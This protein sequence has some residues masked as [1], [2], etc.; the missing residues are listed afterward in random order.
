M[1]KETYTPEEP[2]AAIATAL[3]PAAL[4]IV[5]TSGKNCIDLVSKAFSRPKALKSA[6]GNTLV[7]GWIVDCES[8]GKIDEVMLGVYRNGKSFTGEEMVEIYCHGGTSTVL[9]VYNQMLKAG[10]RAANRGEYTFRAFINGKADLTKAEA[11]K[12]IIGA[13]T[14]QSR[15]RA[16]ERLQG[17][18]NSEISS[19]KAEL[20]HQIAAIE[21]GIEYPEDEHNITE[22]VDFSA[23]NAINQKLKNLAG[24]WATEKLYQ[25]GAAVVL[26]GKTNAGKSSLFNILLKEERAIVSDI[27]GTTRDWIESWANF[28]G[29][30]VRL[31]DTAGL[32]Q[33]DDVIEQNGVE[34]TKELLPQADLVLYVL[35]S[36]AGLSGEDEVFLKELL[37]ENEKTQKV[38]L[39]LNKCDKSQNA[40][41]LTEELKAKFG[42]F[43][44]VN[45][46]AKSG[47]GL[48]ELTNKV[49]SLLQNSQSSENSTIGLGSKR[50]KQAVEEAIDSLN[51]ALS[52]AEL[53]FGSDAVVQDI[54]DALASLGELTGEVTSDDILQ[55]VFS[56]FCV[57]K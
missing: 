55:S 57:G 45:V 25:D 3:V 46:S 54:E 35:D 6:Q 1:A 31:F 11:V 47:T 56:A 8:G 37:G 13:K 21:V 19:I 40:A 48:K 30:P 39:V 34:R 41:A 4:G 53:G 16:A 15:S 18:L 32:R 14:D 24:S 42:D 50:Q 43:N 27:H 12:E 17:A 29:I 38:L 9:G 23:L 2:I 5:R 10:F 44:S 51:H 28:D 49:A 33:T 36:C 26:C 22:E 52:C 7:Y 20:L